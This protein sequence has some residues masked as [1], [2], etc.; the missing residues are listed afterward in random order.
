MAGHGD[1]ISQFAH[2]LILTCRACERQGA[3]RELPNAVVAVPAAVQEPLG[4]TSVNGRTGSFCC[5]TE[6]AGLPGTL[7]KP[8][9]DRPIGSEV[10]GS[11]PVGSEAGG[12]SVNGRM[13]SVTESR[14]A[15][16]PTSCNSSD[17]DICENPLAV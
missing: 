10:V 1:G 9:G 5:D 4:G 11:G 6:P 7:G 15:G 3:S 17:G 12:I 8:D 14:V 13:G 2:T 16:S